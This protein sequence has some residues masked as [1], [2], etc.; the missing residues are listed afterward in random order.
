MTGLLNSSGR[1]IRSTNRTDCLYN[2]WERR[3][4]P[5]E[6]SPRAPE[7]RDRDNFRDNRAKSVIAVESL[8]SAS[9]LCDNS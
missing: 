8:K 5:R 6:A 9:P 7:D 2:P 1:A 4:G 3:A